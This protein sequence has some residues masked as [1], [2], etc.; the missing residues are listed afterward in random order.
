MK[1]LLILSAI[2]VSA[3][4]AVA[5]PWQQPEI[6]SKADRSTVEFVVRD[7]KPILMDIYQ[8][9]DQKT[10]GKRPHT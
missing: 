7:A 8:F 9:K 4:S 10:E 6:V 3:W 1:K 2:L 5:Q